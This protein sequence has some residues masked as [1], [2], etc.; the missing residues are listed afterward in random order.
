[1]GGHPHVD[2]SSTSQGLDGNSEVSLRNSMGTGMALQT[3]QGPWGL[4]LF[5]GGGVLINLRGQHTAKYF[6]NS[7]SRQAVNLLSEMLR[8]EVLQISFSDL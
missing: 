4:R 7:I 8:P 6:I 2:G 5:Q 1:M 3:P